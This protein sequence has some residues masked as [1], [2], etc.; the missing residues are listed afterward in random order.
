MTTKSKYKFVLFIVLFNLFVLNYIFSFYTSQSKLANN[1]KSTPFYDI[2][3]KYLLGKINYRKDKNF[4]AVEEAYCSKPTYLLKEVYD[5]FKKMHDAAKKEGV[6]LV[7]VSGTRNFEE[8]KSIWDRK[9]KTNIK[10]SDT[11][12]C[13]KKI[14]LFSSMP[15]TSRH[16]WGTDMDLINLNNSYFEKGQGLKE[17]TWLKTNASKFGFCQV[18]DDKKLTNRTGYELEKWHWSYLPKA[19]LFL[20]QY[21]EKISYKDINNFTGCNFASNKKIDMINNFVEGI[22][23]DCQ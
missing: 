19:K 4:I 22:S 12:S 14:L 21:K 6:K 15:C 17:Y 20:K 2:E 9:F 23:K 3:K 8:Q 13:I 16:H 5:N 10:T 7:I 1:P 11:I 18:Y